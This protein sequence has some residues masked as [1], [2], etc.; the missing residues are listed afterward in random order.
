LGPDL[1]KDVDA[2]KGEVEG[3]KCEGL[4]IDVNV[5]LGAGC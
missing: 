5:K 3:L 2:F 1:K 4:K